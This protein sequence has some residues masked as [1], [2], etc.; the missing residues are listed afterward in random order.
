MARDRIAEDTL[1]KPVKIP[2]LEKAGYV[3]KGNRGVRQGEVRTFAA[4]TI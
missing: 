4:G 3:L 2:N 1:A